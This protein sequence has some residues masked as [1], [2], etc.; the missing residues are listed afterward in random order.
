MRHTYEIKPTNFATLPDDKKLGALT[1]F[2]RFLAAIQK[3]ARI[4][5][6]KEYISLEIGA[7]K[8]LLP[9]PRTFLI[10][11]ESLEQILEHAGLEYSLV[12]KEPRWMVKSESLN[13]LTL[14]DDALARC[15]SLYKVPFT[16]PAAW[17]SSLLSYSEMISV[18]LKPIENHKA[19]S[20]IQR[21]LGLVAAGANTSYDLK[22]RTEK[23]LAVLDAL[24]KQQTNCFC[25][26]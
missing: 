26:Q 17:I 6:Q 10:S 22:Y 1:K 9:L 12:A 19:V 2:Y 24:T 18:W 7:D 8:K 5:T 23:G 14:D 13:Y 3:P 20:Q 15:Y 21:Y 25:S 11:G 16:L 4:I